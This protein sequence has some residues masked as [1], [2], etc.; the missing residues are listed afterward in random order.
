[1]KLDD[2]FRTLDFR[3]L[4][5]WMFR[6]SRAWTCSFL[7]SGFF[8]FSGSGSSVFLD[9]DFSFL[10]IWISAFFGPGLLLSSDLDRSVSFK[11]LD[12]AFT[13]S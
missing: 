9:L 11:V 7:G 10:R 13:S 5:I 1:V 12:S 8:S 3:F 2:S 6:F 4:R